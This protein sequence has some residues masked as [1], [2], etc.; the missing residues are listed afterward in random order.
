VGN[1][2]VSAY[3]NA[4]KTAVESAKKSL[5]FLNATEL[6]IAVQCSAV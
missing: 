5:H 6:N 4:E 2:L 1:V 3:K